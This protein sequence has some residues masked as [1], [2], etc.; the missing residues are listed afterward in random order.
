MYSVPHRQVAMHIYNIVKSLRKAATLANVSHSTIARWVKFGVDKK[1]YAFQKRPSW[2]KMT[3]DLVSLLRATIDSNPFISVRQLQSMIA[4]TLNV[5]VSRE[6]VRI[7]I[8]RQGLTK[9][10]ARFY[11]V[12]AAQEKETK[13]FLAT[14][15]EYIANGRSFVAI[16]ETSFGR[17][18]RVTKGYAP[19][20]RALHVRKKQPYIKT[21]SAV[22][23]VSPSGLVAKTILAGAF[24]TKKFVEFLQS[25]DLAGTVVLLDNVSFHHSNEVASFASA[26]NIELLFV[27]PYSPWFNPIENCFSIVKRHFY[28][29]QDI[30]EAFA[31]LTGDHCQS[32]FSKCM[33]L[34]GDPRR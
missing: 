32:F 20:G 17:H 23:C 27:P 33:G 11:G 19:K 16:D 34:E 24:N 7:A 9:K 30:E 10:T 22:A 12:S 29:H 25:M 2:Q 31:A 3:D 18:G 6:L 8:K 13:A 26:N 1:R 15:S 21:K 28:Q 14:R 4:T 5:V